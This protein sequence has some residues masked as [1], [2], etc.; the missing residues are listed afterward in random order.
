MMLTIKY[1]KLIKLFK[2]HSIVLGVKAI[3]YIVL[4]LQK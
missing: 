2:G 1:E 3:K 4:I